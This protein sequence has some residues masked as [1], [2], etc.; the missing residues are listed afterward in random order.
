[1]LSCR[2]EVEGLDQSESDR[3][4]RLYEQQHDFIQRMAI[5]T[6]GNHALANDL[7]QETWLRAWLA[8]DS[9]LNIEAG[10]SWLMTILKRENARLYS[11]KS[12]DYCSLEDL[13]EEPAVSENCENGILVNQLLS[14]LQGEDR[15]LL[16][17]RVFGD[18]SYAEIAEAMQLTPN[19]VAIRLHR[20]RKTMASL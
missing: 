14:G 1:M 6:C 12:L 16:E 17:S 18:M 13:Q 20:L 11:R 10:R 7:V 4:S 15:Y 3:F 8:I 2:V 5:I 9:L 19:T